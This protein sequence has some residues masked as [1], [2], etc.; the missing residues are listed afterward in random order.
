MLPTLRGVY[1]TITPASRINVKCGIRLIA[2]LQMT[3]C[4]INTDVNGQVINV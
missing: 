2:P 4:F 3:K 1:G